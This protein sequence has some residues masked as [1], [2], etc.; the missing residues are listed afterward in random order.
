MVELDPTG[1]F[2][3][4]PLQP[5]Q[6]T[7]RIT[8]AEDTIVLCHLGVPR[9]LP[10][11][12][13]LTIG[14][15]VRR[16][17]RLT[18]ADIKRRARVEVAGVHQCAGSPIEPTVPKRRVCAVVW[19]GV[20]LADVLDDCEPLDGARFLC[21]SGADYGEFNGVACD[22]Y[23]KDLPID[24]IEQDVLL[25]YDMN[26]A[27]LSPEN[28]YPVRLVVPGFYGTNSVK[29]LTHMELADRRAAGPFTTRWYND[30]VLDDAGQPTGA[31]RPVWGIAPESIIVAPAAGATLDLG[32]PVT[33]WGWA[34]ADG[35]VSTV[36]VSVDDCR[37]WSTAALEPP[38]GRMWQ[39]FELHWLPDAS[40]P[41]EI[42]ARA[43]CSDGF[44]QPLF[45]ARN[46]VHRVEIG[47][48]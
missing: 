12:W 10:E 14:G 24:R 28:G 13:S 43:M 36:E 32:S 39:K 46:A 9:I 4:L 38:S 21:S 30:P 47:V 8:R 26:N 3:R 18:L 29:W 33:V 31:T 6:L 17:L 27:P 2:C 23:T 11:N 44:C 1:F 37:T 22:A 48:S 35:G 25:A 15:L 41:H 40:G 42:G 5:H 45:G 7:E 34:W 19:G 16:K 20:R